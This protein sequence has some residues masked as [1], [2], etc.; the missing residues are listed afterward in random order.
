[1]FDGPSHE[2]SWVSLLLSFC[3]PF[4]S[5]V[6]LY[7]GSNWDDARFLIFEMIS[8]LNGIIHPLSTSF[9][10]VLLINSRSFFVLELHLW[11]PRSILAI[12]LFFNV[13]SSIGE[14]DV[15]VPSVKKRLICSSFYIVLIAVLVSKRF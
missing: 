11:F 8:F 9:V 7:D 6:Y 13:S 14:N 4:S 12:Q 10:Y 5:I 1:M 15:S 2:Q 3:F